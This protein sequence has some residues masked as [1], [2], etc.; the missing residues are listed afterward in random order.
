MRDVA[1][2]GGMVVY[3]LFL[4]VLCYFFIFY[5]MFCTLLTRGCLSWL[6][7]AVVG[8]LGC[9]RPWLLILHEEIAEPSIPGC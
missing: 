4:T 7:Q 6:Y 8:P 1:G 9:S 3:N 5:K 2:F